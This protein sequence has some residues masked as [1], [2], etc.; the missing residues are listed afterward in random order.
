MPVDLKADC[1]SRSPLILFSTP[2]VPPTEATEAERPKDL[3][4]QLIEARVNCGS[5]P[6]SAG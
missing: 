1:K 4:Y 3:F 5:R 6:K 2:Y